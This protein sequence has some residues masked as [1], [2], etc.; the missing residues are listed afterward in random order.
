MLVF[1]KGPKI[2]KSAPAFSPVVHC[3]TKHLDLAQLSFAQCT[4]VVGVGDQVHEKEK[5]A[6]T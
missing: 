5:D 4:T 1:A 3:L 2:A 6:S